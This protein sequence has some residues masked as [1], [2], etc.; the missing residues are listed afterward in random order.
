MPGKRRKPTIRDVASLAGVSYQTVSFVVN[1]TGVISNDTRQR[2]LDA[3]KQLNYVPN[4]TARSLASGRTRVIALLIPDTQNPHFWHLVQGVQE[5]ASARGY[6]LL[7]A[8]SDL[9][10]ERERSA[11]SALARQQLD[12]LILMPLFPE[13]E[14]EEIGVLMRQGKPISGLL[15]AEYPQIDRVTWRYELA[16]RM[17]M[18]HLLSLGHRRIGVIR[19]VPRPDAAATRVRSY[20]HC[21]QEAG[22]PVDDRLVAQC[23]PLLQD[24]D[25]AA[26][27]LLAL[28]PRPTAIVGINDLMAFAAQQASLRH[29]LR[30]PQDVSIAGFDDIDMA[31]F[32]APPL[33]TVRL[34]GLETGQQLAQLL[35]ARLADP[36]LPPRHVEM[37]AELIVRGSTGPCTGWSS[38]V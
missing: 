33:T 20:Y 12:G 25:R 6:S 36:D 22:I 13:S 19:G 30:V 26:D 8:T 28:R 37:P 23:G 21:L 11:L 27:R 9:D 31:A 18:D 16:T 32:L 35:F 14:K 15:G 5:V 29:G 17:L 10:P 1:G 7:L 3:V 38:N 24:G 4:A 34:R 2:V